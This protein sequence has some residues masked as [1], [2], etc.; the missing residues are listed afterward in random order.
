MCVRVVC[1]P[2]A[3]S[4]AEWRANL[5]VTSFLAE[6]SAVQMGSVLWTQSGFSCSQM[7]EG[8]GDLFWAPSLSNICFVLR[9]IHVNSSSKA[10][11]V[12][13]IRISPSRSH[14]FMYIVGSQQE[15]YE[16]HPT[17]FV[18]YRHQ[19]KVTCIMANQF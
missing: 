18:V 5:C 14:K 16:I 10:T 8:L 9:K 15:L 19:R 17:H 6:A 11:I 12:T 7:L 1:M 13:Q 2:V 4:Y 3:Y